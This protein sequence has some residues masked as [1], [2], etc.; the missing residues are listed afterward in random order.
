MLDETDQ[1]DDARV[2]KH[3]TMPIPVQQNVHFKSTT[4]YSGGLMANNYNKLQMQLN[5]RYISQI[6]CPRRI[7]VSLPHV[8]VCPYIVPQRSRTKSENSD[9]SSLM[10][11]ET[12]PAS[13]AVRTS[14]NCSLMMETCDPS[15]SQ[16]DTSNQQQQLIA[17]MP[18]RR[19]TLV[20]SKSLENLAQVARPIDGSQPS[21][22]MEFVS[23]RIQKLKVQ[24]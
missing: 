5:T 12:C 3:H 8:R 18:E 15:F 6:S 24:E 11:L 10:N 2:Q 9:T 7:R 19:N 20:K 22:E 13:D 1:K 14:L 4:E 21:H 16:M 17:S 23:S